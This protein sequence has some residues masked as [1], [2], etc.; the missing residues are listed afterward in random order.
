MSTPPGRAPKVGPIR[1]GPP[2]KWGVSPRARRARVSNTEPPQDRRRLSCSQARVRACRFLTVSHR[3]SGQHWTQ[4][5][6]LDNWRILTCGSGLWR[7]CWTCGIDLRICECRSRRF[8]V[9]CHQDRCRRYRV[10]RYGSGR[11]YACLSSD[12]SLVSP[13]PAWPTALT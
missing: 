2:S 12:L 11:E 3:L 1:Q 9:D 7:T 4:A 6:S 13:A 5:Y 8:W 10:T